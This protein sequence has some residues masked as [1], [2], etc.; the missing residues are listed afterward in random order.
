MID[1]KKRSCI[2]IDVAVPAD[3]R[4]YEKGKE[5]VEKYQDLRRENG[6]IWP[7]RKVQVVS[8]VIGALGSVTKE[9]DRRIEKL[10]IPG[11]V[12]VIQKTALLG[13]SRIMRIVLEM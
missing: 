10:G 7:L 3:G 5:N 4:V 6:R 11:D 8:M 9:S 2:I 13:T 12:G 1:K